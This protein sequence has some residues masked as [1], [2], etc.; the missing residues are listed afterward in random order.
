MALINLPLD[1][2]ELIVDDLAENDYNVIKL[3]SIKACALVCHSFLPL[4]R[5]HIFAFVTLNSRRP[6]SP[7]SDDLN[8]L[9]SNLPHLAVHIRTLYYYFNKKEF[10]AKRISWLI[11]MFK[12]LVNLRYLRMRFSGSPSVPD[13]KLNWMSSPERKVLLPLLHLPTLIDIGLTRIGNFPLAD[14]ASCVNLKTLRIDCLEC[15]T[16]NSVGNFFLETIPATP[17]MLEWLVIIMG[18]IKPVLQ[19]CHARRPDGKPIIDFSSLKKITASVPQLNSLWELF[20]MFRNLRRVRLT[21]M[22]LPHLI[23]TSF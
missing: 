1:V 20:V 8:H 10:V 13:R 18:N 12:K 17:V 9:L 5:K 16:P 19:L 23:S 15:S 7:T 6:P 2:V 4:C 22:S 3:P 14:L 21:S 11:P